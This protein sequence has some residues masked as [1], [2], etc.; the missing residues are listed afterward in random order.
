[1]PLLYGDRAQVVN[2]TIRKKD[3]SEYRFYHEGRAGGSYTKSL[4]LENGFAIVTDEWD[5]QTIVP[6]ADIAEITTEPHRHY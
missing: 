4:K 2:I 1:M 5:K 6:S 3:G